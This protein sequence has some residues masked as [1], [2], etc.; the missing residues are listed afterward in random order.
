MNHLNHNSYSAD[1][2][3]RVK[4]A[5]LNLGWPYLLH[6]IES[7]LNVRCFSHKI[8]QLALV[9]IYLAVPVSKS[10]YKKKRNCS[11]KKRQKVIMKANL[12]RM[13]H[14]KY[15]NLIHWTRALVRVI[16]NSQNGFHKSQDLL[17]K[18]TFNYFKRRWMIRA[19]ERI[20]GWMQADFH[21]YD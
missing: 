10:S 1:D 2:I 20:D 11:C 7:I 17:N 18:W 3:S 4:R 13:K 5:V 15:R 9:S 8:W 12:T 21:S 14:I 6:W 16:C 19:E